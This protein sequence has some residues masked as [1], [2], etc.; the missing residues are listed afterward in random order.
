MARHL[1]IL[2]KGLDMNACWVL[3]VPSDFSTGIVRSVYGVLRRLPSTVC[4]T[5]ESEYLGLILNFLTLH[6]L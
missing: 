4:S 5:V 3:S 6:L 2:N 1:A